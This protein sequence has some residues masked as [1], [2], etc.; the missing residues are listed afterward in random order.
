MLVYICTIFV[1]VA[2]GQ[3]KKMHLETDAF[4]I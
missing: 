4:L 3:A 2:H 1:S